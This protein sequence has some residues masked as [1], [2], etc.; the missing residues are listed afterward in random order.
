VRINRIIRKR[1]R[2]A[3]GGATGD[4]HAALAVNVGE[5]GDSH[6]HVSTHSRI[7]QGE[8]HATTTA[9]PAEP[10]DDPKEAA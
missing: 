9:P 5:A 6:A 1:L 4:L 8:A 10:D 7:V 2:S 3:D